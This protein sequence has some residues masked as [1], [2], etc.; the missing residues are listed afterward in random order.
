VYNKNSFVYKEGEPIKG[1]YIIVKGDF[2]VTC[3][4]KGKRIKEE[5][6]CDPYL[7][8]YKNMSARDEK[9]LEQF[10]INNSKEVHRNLKMTMLSEG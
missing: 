6:E 8:K 9:F 4:E 3:Y 10:H 5:Q 7:T 2:Q 1:I